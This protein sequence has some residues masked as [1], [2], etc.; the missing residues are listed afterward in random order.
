M[1]WAAIPFFYCINLDKNPGR[2]DKCV[3]EFIRVGIPYVKQV[4][5]HESEDNRYISFNH[6]HYDTIKEGYETGQP[7]CIFE[8][9]VIFDRNWHKIEDAMA[10]LPV[11]WDML[12]LGCNFSSGNEWQMPIRESRNL[13]RLFNA[14]QSHA[15]VYSNK[16]AKFILDNFD[17]ETFPVYDEWLRMNMMP[18]HN[19]YVMAPMICDQRPG[20]SDIW[21]KDVAYGCHVEGN[22]WIKNN[23]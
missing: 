21:Q 11:E 17:P 12:Y 15:I 13:L 20:Y 4:V 3:D 6:A 7:F 2:W 9:D 10:Q 16:A 8:D 22:E 1:K 23:L 14:W 5:T 19:V 18:S